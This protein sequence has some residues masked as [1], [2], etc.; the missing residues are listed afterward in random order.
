MVGPSGMAS[1]AALW[2]SST[3][4]VRGQSSKAQMAT[5]ATNN[6]AA[7]PAANVLDDQGFVPDVGLASVTGVTIAA[8]LSLKTTLNA[9]TGRACS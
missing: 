8:D 1:A 4:E 2:N 6:T 9:L 5:A 3:V 7:T